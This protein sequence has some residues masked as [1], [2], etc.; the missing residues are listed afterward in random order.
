MI[1]LASSA[2]TSAIWPRRSWWNPAWKRS[3]AR[4]GTRR[5]QVGPGT[6]RRWVGAGTGERNDRSPP[7]PGLPSRRPSLRP[8]RRTRAMSEDTL[9]TQAADLEALLPKLMRRLFTLDPSH[10]ANEL[11]VAQLRVCTILQAG[12]R[13][14]SAISEELGISVS[15]VT[16]IAD[17]LER[18][19]F[20]ERVAGQDDRR[21]K[22]LQLTLHG[23]EVMRSRRER[24]VRGAAAA[25]EQLPPAARAEVLHALHVLLDASLAIAPRVTEEEP[26]GVGLGQQ[27]LGTVGLA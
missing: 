2:R 14:V 17:R 12:P 24:R 6:H 19:G 23:A 16:Q 3:S 8:S 11:P 7:P 9:L 13:T 4:P 25:L 18:A 22:R 21:M 27:P 10:P 5:S 20:V 26:V 15:A 1:S